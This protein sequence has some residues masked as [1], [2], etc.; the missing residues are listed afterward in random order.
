[1]ADRHEQVRGRGRFPTRAQVRWT[2]ETVNDP[3][4]LVVCTNKAPEAAG[5]ARS[6]Q[7]MAIVARA[8]SGTDEGRHGY[9]WSA[10]LGRD[11]VHAIDTRRHEARQR[12]A[13][14]GKGD[15]EIRRTVEHVRRAA[16]ACALDRKWRVPCETIG[17]TD[18]TGVPADRHAVM[19]AAGIGIERACRAL[20]TNRVG[21]IGA[22]VY[23]V[24]GRDEDGDNVIVLVIDAAPDDDERAWARNELA[25]WS[26]VLRTIHGTIEPVTSTLVE[27]RSTGSSQVTVASLMQTA[28]EQAARAVRDHTALHAVRE[29][30]EEQG[31]RHAE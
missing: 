13:E 15:L 26:E 23:P 27:L 16:H 1:M 28:S 29:H 7:S 4:A 10:V 19:F 22:A 14:Q 25:Q 11:L 21:A 30:I 5:L 18:M 20:D 9:P 8:C 6:F 24:P 31:T 12:L 2:L 3:A 17:F